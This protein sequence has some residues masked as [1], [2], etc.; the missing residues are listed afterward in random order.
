VSPA[1]EFSAVTAD[2]LR[3]GHPVRFR[4]T[5]RSMAP[6]I[7]EGERITC[8]PVDPA[9]ARRGDIL[10]YHT[11][12]GVIA[13]RVVAVRRE[14]AGLTFHLRGDACATADQP[15]AAAQVLGRVTAVERR[16]REVSLHGPLP[17]AAQAA[18][19]IAAHL[20]NRLK[21]EGG[22]RADMEVAPRD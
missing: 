16:G 11:G 5:G 4:A 10:L 17:R 3:A 21:R 12:R 7:R 19:R 20:K 18:R 2:L 6:T 15:V 8:H 9:A 22:R 13:H 14:A 1:P